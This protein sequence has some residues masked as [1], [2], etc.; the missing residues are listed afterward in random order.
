MTAN[1]RNHTDQSSSIKDGGKPDNL[2]QAFLALLLTPVVAIGDGLVF[3]LLWHLFVAPLF[4]LPDLSLAQ[5]IGLTFTISF[6]T[7]TESTRRY[8]NAS[9]ADALKYMFFKSVKKYVMT[10][11]IAYVIALFL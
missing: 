6:V 3:S 7:D 5:A 8:D 4:G 2:L 1:V 11:I 10:V 9:F